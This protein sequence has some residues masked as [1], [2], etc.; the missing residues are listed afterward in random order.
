MIKGRPDID[1][2]KYIYIQSEILPGLMFMD[3]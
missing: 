2:D 3:D 1:M